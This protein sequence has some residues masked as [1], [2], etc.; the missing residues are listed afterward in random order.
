MAQNKT[1]FLGGGSLFK[2][3]SSGLEKNAPSNFERRFEQEHFQLNF[4][5]VA[6]ILTGSEGQ[7]QFFWLE[8]LEIGKLKTYLFLILLKTTF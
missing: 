4:M 5:K 1:F 3:S 7:I 6:F 8:V 2:G